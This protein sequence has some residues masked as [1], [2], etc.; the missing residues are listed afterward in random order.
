[1]V[2]SSLFAL[3]TRMRQLT[4]TLTVRF[5]EG[6]KLPEI[7]NALTTENQGNKLVLEVAVRERWR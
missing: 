2:W 5:S 1:M 7:L 4:R 6:E 3:R